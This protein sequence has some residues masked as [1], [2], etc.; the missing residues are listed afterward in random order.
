M[1][2]D[3]EAIQVLREFQDNLFLK[4]NKEHKVFKA[5]LFLEVIIVIKV[6]HLLTQ[7][8]HLNN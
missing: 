7:T 6:I 5:Q 3:L 2:L 4:L 1:N 8:L